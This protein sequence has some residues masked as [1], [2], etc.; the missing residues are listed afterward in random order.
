MAVNTRAA[1]CPAMAGIPGRGNPVC[2]QQLLQFTEE[3]RPSLAPRR[4]AVQPGDT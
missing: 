1:R 4:S 2:L 3:R